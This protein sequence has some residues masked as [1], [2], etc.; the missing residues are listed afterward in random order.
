MR[1]TVIGSLE[2]LEREGGQ[3]SE[4]RVPRTR[5]VTECPLCG[6][7]ELSLFFRTTDRLHRTPG[8]FTYRRCDSCSTVFQDPRI[9]NDDL[10]LIYPFDY[11]THKPAD[12]SPA[13]PTVV[14]RSLSSVRD[15]LRRSVVE[16]VINGKRPGLLA[17]I[18]RLLAASPYVRERAFHNYVPD[19]LLPFK[20]GRLRALEIGC[21]SGK[22]LR[23]LSKVG[24]EVEGIEI[25]PIAAQLARLAS[26]RPVW[27]G[28]FRNAPLRARSYD[29]IVLN[30]VFE[31]LDDP[32]SVLQRARPRGTGGSVLSQ[33]IG[34]GRQDL[35]G[36]LACV[37]R[38]ASSRIA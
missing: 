4:P 22:L 27:E 23:C 6:G 12:A 36:R 18:A 8:E 37:G 21:G 35:W 25:D 9:I 3:S 17:R 5:P 26:G 31:H 20:P 2:L 14:S 24:W 28:E 29:L 38:A 30:H 11:M 15:R 34:A 13:V 33:S 32:I 16:A 1:H 10:H 7:V 19:V